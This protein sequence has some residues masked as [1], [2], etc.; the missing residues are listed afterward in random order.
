MIRTHAH[1]R[2]GR[3]REDPRDRRG[4]RVV[5]TLDRRGRSGGSG[6]QERGEQ[7]GR[8]HLDGG[9]EAWARTGSRRSGCAARGFW[10]RGVPLS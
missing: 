10:P 2:R 8:D 1:R 9:R 5:A 7:G 6:G 3:R 4:R